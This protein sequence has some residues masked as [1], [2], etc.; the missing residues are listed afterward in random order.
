[1]YNRGESKALRL[2]RVQGDGQTGRSSLTTQV[3]SKEPPRSKEAASAMASLVEDK[4]VAAALSAEDSAEKRL[5]FDATSQLR[6]KTGRSDSGKLCLAYLEVPT[7]DYFHALEQMHDGLDLPVGTAGVT[8]D[9][10]TVA[11]CTR[12]GFRFRMGPRSGSVE[13]QG[14]AT[15]SMGFSLM[16][17]KGG[18]QFFA[19]GYKGPPNRELLER[20]AKLVEWSVLTYGVSWRQHSRVAQWRTSIEAEAARLPPVMVLNPGGLVRCMETLRAVLVVP[21]QDARTESGAS[22]IEERGGAIGKPSKPEELQTQVATGPE[23]REQRA[24][25]NT[26]EHGS[27]F[28]TTERARA[29]W[30]RRHRIMLRV[31][32]EVRKRSEK[33]EQRAPTPTM[34]EYIGNL[35]KLDRSGKRLSER[36]VRRILKARREGMFTQ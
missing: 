28:P 23:A 1:M 9:R 18:L 10:D 13:W 11:E 19:S 36:H 5:F 16:P 30:R 4:G 34:D 29:V 3:S 31:E 15:V 25:V 27:Y 22:R 21:G 32:A 6:T 12:L 20:W 7:E 33:G 24:R 26:S 17:L 14:D 8:S 35:A 2:R